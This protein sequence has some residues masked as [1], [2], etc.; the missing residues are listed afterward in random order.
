MKNEEYKKNEEREQY[1]RVRK[2]K[3]G[4][5]IDH[6]KPEYTLDIIKILN[7]SK[8]DNIITAAINVPSSKTIKRKGVIK[9]EDKLLTDGETSIIALL[10]PNATINKIK[11]WEVAEKKNVELPSEFEG[12]I[13]CRNPTCITNKREPREIVVPKFYVVSKEPVKVK[14]HYCDI[15]MDSSDIINNL[16]RYEL[17]Y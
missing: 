12:I 10:S 13:C 1:L 2:I 3:N 14:C 6:L 9:I 11:N 7:L 4:T 5:V 16:K 17:K 15:T 8:W